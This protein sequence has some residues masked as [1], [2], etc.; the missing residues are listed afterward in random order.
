MTLLEHGLKWLKSEFTIRELKSLLGSK[1]SSEK[2]TSKAEN[3]TSFSDPTAFP[4]WSFD[5]EHVLIEFFIN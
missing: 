4:F 1:A 5:V 2:S 3:L